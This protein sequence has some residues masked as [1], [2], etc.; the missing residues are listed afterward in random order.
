[1]LDFISL[2]YPLSG[3]DFSFMMYNN[4]MIDDY[5]VNSPITIGSEPSVVKWN[6]VRG[7][8]ASALFEWY[9]D[10]EVTLK[11]TTTWTY[12]A[13]AY[14]PKTSTKYTLT[15]TPGT[16]NVTVSIPNAIST[17]WGT[18]VNAIVAELNFDLQITINSKKWTPIVGTI[19][20][21]LDIT[22]SSL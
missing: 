9:E 6:I 16:G 3:T 14:D 22:G 17:T 5:G 2:S 4:N 19:I 15:C 13:S 11:D 18:G 7:D 21:R 8:D 10:D 1:V 12:A 20:V